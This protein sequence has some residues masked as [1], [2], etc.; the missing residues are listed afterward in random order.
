MYEDSC[1]D[2]LGFDFDS[3]CS[4]F[5]LGWIWLDFGWIWLDWALAGFGSILLRLLL[6]LAW[7]WLDFALS[8]ASM[9]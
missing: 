3:I 9:Y 8:L 2:F 7:I 1:Q 5:D 6:D 4:R